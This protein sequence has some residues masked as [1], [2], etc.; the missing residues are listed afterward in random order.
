M[1]DDNEN[2]Y[3]EQ[4]VD[5]PEIMWG[6]NY[7]KYKQYLEEFTVWTNKKQ[8]EIY[9]N[10]LL[11][12][13]LAIVFSILVALIN[14]EL[15]ADL[16]IQTAGAGLTFILIERFWRGYESH[17]SRRKEREMKLRLIL[18][19]YEKLIELEK[20][21]DV[22]LWIKTNRQ[23]PPTEAIVDYTISSDIVKKRIEALEWEF[24][25]EEF[26]PRG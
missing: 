4:D 14:P 11:I 25:A 6:R 24:P 1:A 5:D 3:P 17:I 23:V 15:G 19:E 13:V 22:K 20:R 26:L 16:F 21:D 8:Q 12:I 9:I 7:A 2:P 18:S 10:A